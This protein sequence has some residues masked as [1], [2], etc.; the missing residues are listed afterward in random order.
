[1]NTLRRKALVG[2]RYLSFQL[3][4][5]TYGI[6]ILAV[7]E[8]MGM[9]AITTLPKTPEFIQ[10]VINLRGQIIPIID[11]RLKFGLPF[12]A[13]HKRTSI[14]VVEV[15]VEGEKVLMGLVV[16]AIEEVVGIPPDKISRVPYI[17]AKVKADFIQGI[18]ETPDGILILLDIVRIL[19]EE[20]FVL[21]K[22]TAQPKKKESS[23]HEN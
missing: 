17:N 12:Q 18:A 23:S 15:E 1:M 7:R 10:G 19:K 20:E 8:L 4:A 11:L 13:Y 2:D 6:S 5:E 16:D 22:N 21:V 3:E 14:M 9:V